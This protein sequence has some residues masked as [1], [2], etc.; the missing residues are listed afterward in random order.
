MKCSMCGMDMPSERLLE[1]MLGNQ[2]GMKITFCESCL[3]TMLLE[4]KTQYIEKH[5]KTSEEKSMDSPEHKTDLFTPS[6]IKAELDKHVIGQDDAKK[7]LAVAVYNHY[8]RISSKEKISKSNVLLIGP[9]GTGKTELCR[10]LAEA[11]DVPFIITD[12]TTYTQSGYVGEDVE[13][14]LYKLYLAADKDI[15]RAEHGIVFIDEIDKIARKGENTSITRDVSGEGVQ[16]ALLK[17][18]E[19]SVVNVS[20]GK[21]K[22]PDEEYLQMNT[23]NILFICGGAFEGLTMK[24]KTT[25]APLGFGV[26]SGAETE[27]DSKITHEDVIKYGLLPEFMGRLPILVQLNPLTIDDLQRI[28]IEPEDSLVKQYQH[29]LAPIKFSVDKEALY[30]IAQKSFVKQTGARGLRTELESVMQD[31]MYDLP[32]EKSVKKVV[33]TVKDNELF[34]DKQIG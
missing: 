2:I 1:L 18:I 19:G 8:K 14:I 26:N 25:H 9:S 17:L 3:K 13:Q 28:L 22:R 4:I 34:I 30:H 27:K 24:P 16:Q 33:M 29:L 31:L 32:D 6:R 7:A 15:E 10:K 11:I 20:P 12:A 21:R 5:E 23:E